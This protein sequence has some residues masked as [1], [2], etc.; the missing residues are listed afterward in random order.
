MSSWTD[1]VG[2]SDRAALKSALSRSLKHVVV[3]SDA[4]RFRI[5]ASVPIY[6]IALA[7]AQS[8]SSLE[9]SASPT[10]RVLY[11]ITDES[12]ASFIAAV[13]ATVSDGIVQDVRAISQAGRDASVAAKIRDLRA[14]ETIDA[15]R[16]LVTP[17][18]MLTAIWTH[19]SNGAPNDT[20]VVGV[21]PSLQVVADQR[22]T[23]DALLNVFRTVRP[24]SGVRSGIDD[25]QGSRT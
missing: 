18:H 22:Y 4:K 9:D 17:Q 7:R 24:I 8:G 19:H 15:L 10:G 5:G 23:E 6:R 25:E 2:L 20:W 13:T 16:L 14:D 3:G 21:R 1:D 11:E 12:D